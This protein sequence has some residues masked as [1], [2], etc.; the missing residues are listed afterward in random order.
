MWKNGV[1]FEI[2]LVLKPDITYLRELKEMRL[3]GDSHN[4]LSIVGSD[5]NVARLK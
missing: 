5:Q 1:N 2:S 3:V 4:F